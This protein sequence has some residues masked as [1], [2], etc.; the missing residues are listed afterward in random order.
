MK[1]AKRTYEVDAIRSLESKAD[2]PKEFWDFLKGM[3]RKNQDGNRPTSDEWV[4]HFSSLYSGNHSLN[5][6][7]NQK[8]TNTIKS[9]S[10]RL[11]P[12]DD[13]LNPTD[14]GIYPFYPKRHLIM[15]TFIGSQFL[16]RLCPHQPI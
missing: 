15:K 1:G 2:N 12:C 11:E 13:G 10:R 6:S 5:S 8:I 9:L 16:Y 4:D 3:G 7:S 14:R